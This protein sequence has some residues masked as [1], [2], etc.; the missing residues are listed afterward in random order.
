MMNGT[1]ADTRPTFTYD[2]GYK[3]Y[4]CTK[5]AIVIQNKKYIC[6]TCYLK[7]NKI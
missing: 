7:K 3:C 5:D 4:Y 2:H 1:S 6:A